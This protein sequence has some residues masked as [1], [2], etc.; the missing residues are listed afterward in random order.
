MGFRAPRSGPVDR[1][2]AVIAW[3]LVLA[4]SLVALHILLILFTGGYSFRSAG[5]SI[6]GVNLYWPLMLLLTLLLLLRV[7][8]TRPIRSW[9]A[10]QEAAGLFCVSLII[11]LANGVTHWAGDTLPAR[12]LPLSILRNGNFYLDEFLGPLYFDRVDLPFWLRFVNGHYVS[13]YP[14][15]PALLALP[16]YVPSAVGGVSP[17]SPLFEGLEKLC[18]AVI[19]SLSVAIL[20]LVLRRLT[21]RTMSLLA[22]VAYALG[23]SSLSTSSQA[24]WQHGPSQLALTA[25][26][27]CLIS[28]RDEPRWIG[29]SGFPL[30]FA[31]ICRPTDVLIAAPLGVYVLLHHRHK[32]W[33]FVLSGIPPLFFHLWYNVAYWDNLLHSQV[34]V[35]DHAPWTT[36]F[37]EGFAGIL[38]SPGRGLFVYSPIFLLALVGAGLAWRRNGDA[39]LRWLSV[40][41]LLVILVY[42]K[43]Y[44]WWGGHSYGPRLLA[45]L[46]PIL[47]LF[48]Y[49]LGDRLGRSKFLSLVFVVCLVWSVGAH[50]IGAFLP[51][52]SWNARMDVDSH[53]ERLWSVTNNQL[54]NSPRRLF[55]R[56]LIA[57]GG[58]PTSRDA[59]DRRLLSAS[60][61]ANLQPSATVH[62]SAKLQ[63]V[64]EAF[65]EGQA[66]WLASAPR[67]RGAVRLGWRW[68]KE[69]RQIPE[70]EGRIPLGYDIFPQQVY[71]FQAFVDSPS[72]PGL[73][74]LEVGLVS[75]FRAWFSDL[76]VL[77]VRCL[78]TVERAKAAVR[79]T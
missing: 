37:L 14:V 67:D 62:P 57:L 69:G 78:V 28:G 22:A 49:P 33:Q 48:L 71:Q 72:E 5:I 66:V 65:N 45:D 32:A 77:P 39:L 73:Y 21:T 76:G 16:F 18:A 43:W 15:A 9:N 20:Y 55:N 35:F 8:A 44:V 34:P 40:G 54:V 58:I 27:Y 31:V 59:H 70:M 46:S 75:E 3:F 38:F 24:L 17:T 13:W 19:V 6:K 61:R 2:V 10:S 50:A 52:R 42:S 64:V 23:T 1:A 63:F 7:A 25:A 36:P 41:V 56:V 12:Y 30:A 47:T 11:Y 68:F 79:P 4:V 74:V 53:P 51:D 26:L 60:Y 29:L